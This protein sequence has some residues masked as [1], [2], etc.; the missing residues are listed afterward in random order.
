ML[1]IPVRDG[2]ELSELLAGIRLHSGEVLELRL[3]YGPP[4]R[5]DLGDLSRHFAPCQLL[6]TIREKE[7]GG[8]VRW[9]LDEKLALYREALQHGFAV[10]LEVALAQI[11]GF[12]GDQVLL[13]RHHIGGLPKAGELRQEFSGAKGRWLKL[14]VP[15]LPGHR[16]LLLEFLEEHPGSTVIPLGARM[17]ERLA[18]FFM[19]SRMLYAH[20]SSLGATSEGQP[21]L[22]QARLALDLL[23]QPRRE[24][25]GLGRKSRSAYRGKR[26]ALMTL[27]KAVEGVAWNRIHTY[28]FASFSVGLFL[29]GFSFGIAPVATGWYVIPK[30]L[31]VL[32]LAW[33]YAWLVVGISLYG[34]LSDRIGRKRTFFLSMASYAAGGVMLVFSSN[35]EVTLGSLAVILSAAGGE[36][37]TILAA[38]HEIFPAR[39][40][41]KA[42][43]LEI[44]FVSLS[45]LL[46][47]GV[48]YVTV[49]TPELGRQ[50]AGTSVLLTGVCLVLLRLKMPE[51]VRWLE[52]KGREREAAQEAARLG[53][54]VQPSEPSHGLK[55]TGLSK[56]S[57]AFRAFVVGILSFASTAGYGLMTYTLAPMYYPKL[58]PTVFLISGVAEFSAGFLGLLGDRISRKGLIFWSYLFT[59]LT[60]VLIY[61]ALPFWAKSI[62]M[63]WLLLIALNVFVEWGY[64]GEDALKGELWPTKVRGTVTGLVR[65]ISIAAYVPLLYLS[66]QMPL[67]G[68]LMLNVLLWASGTVAAFFWLALGPETGKGISVAVSSGEV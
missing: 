56:K 68:F 33:P 25:T 45:G 16:K 20:H 39:H 49:L 53:A 7:E 51:S 66:V 30:D 62:W 19:G 26:P 54:V 55:A 37:N 14:A 13:S 57:L 58:L 21:S 36:M 22:E 10:D 42:M 44:N 63:F 5:V 46:L 48:S 9:P 3:D 24:G 1:S 35:Y 6:F 65:A 38:T 61:A 47:A 2:T 52:S 32:L 17:E 60:T 12:R 34:P 40:R 8:I 43:M 15:A 50:L 23:N 64:L 31:E 59:L 11:A 18:F 28:T 27:S 29:E 41:G 67:A 4:S